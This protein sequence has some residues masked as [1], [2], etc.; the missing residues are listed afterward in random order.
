MSLP[1]EE[2]QKY[3]DKWQD[4]LRLRDWDIKLICVDKKWRKTGDVKVDRDDKKA[5]LMINAFN[6]TSENFEETII[7]ELLHIKL[8]DM[9]QM[10]E[11]FLN[12]SLGKNQGDPG[13]QFALRQFM[14]LLESTVEDLTKS[15]LHLGG[16]NKELSFGRV[17][18]LVEKELGK[19]KS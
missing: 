2:L 11:N 5:V 8:W 6:P 19:G 16:E 4:I 15:F 18:Q 10:L 13:Y 14:V 12:S 7:H 9:D 17:Q 3:L 1:K